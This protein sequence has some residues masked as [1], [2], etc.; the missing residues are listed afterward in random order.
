MG[1]GDECQEIE[2]GESYEFM[3]NTSQ[4]SIQLEIRNPSIIKN[5][6]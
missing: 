4:T 6:N 1:H 5:P 2:K 3:K